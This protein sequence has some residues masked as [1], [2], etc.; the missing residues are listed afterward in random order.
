MDKNQNLGLSICGVSYIDVNDVST[1]INGSDE[2]H[3]EVTLKPGKNWTNIYF[4]PGKAQFED[5]QDQSNAGPLRNQKLVFPYPGY[6]TANRTEFNKYGYKGYLFAITYNNEM[7]L[8]MGDRE[9]PVR[10]F[11]ASFNKEGIWEITALKKSISPA[12]QLD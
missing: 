8:L 4:T 12:F 7:Q 6:D 10:T 3:K 2:N 1:I 5:P 9:F 11:M